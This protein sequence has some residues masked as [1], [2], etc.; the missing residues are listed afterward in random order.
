[1]SPEMGMD[2]VTPGSE[3]SISCECLIWVDSRLGK[4][5]LQRLSLKWS[6]DVAIVEAVLVVLF[7][8]AFLLIVI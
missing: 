6:L 8:V 1:M 4:R 5:E 2:T 3:F 7:L